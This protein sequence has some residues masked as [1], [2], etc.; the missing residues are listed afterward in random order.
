LC[1]GLPEA[2]TGLRQ[3]YVY[4]QCRSRS[5]PGCY[6]RALQALA[7]VFGALFTAAVC[8]TSGGAVLRNACEDRAV[9]LVTGAAVLSLFVFVLCAGGFAYPAV[10]A[11]IGGA[12]LA[13]GWREAHWSWPRRPKRVSGLLAIAFGVFSVLYLSNAMAPEISFD[14]SRYHLGLVA[15]YLREHGFHRITENMYASLSQGVEMLYLFA[16]AFG[17]HSAA[18]TL[19]F[20]FL[21]AL[22]WQVY[23]YA[24]DRGFTSVAGPA[25][26]LVFASP[27]A[28]VDGT[29]AYNDV[30]VAATAFTLFHLLQLW[31]SRRDR[32]LLIAAGLAAGFAFAAKY[33]AWVAVPYAVGF[34]AWKSRRWK[35]PAMVAICAALLIAPWM[36]KN[37][38]WVHNPVAPFYNHWFPN[39]YV[40]ES[41]ERE[42]RAHMRHYNLASDREIPMQVT[43][44]GSL[45]GLLGPVFLLAPIA[46]LA[47]RRREGGQLLL[48]AA[49]FGSTYFNNIGARFLLPVLP[50]A[51]LA[52]S[53]ALAQWPRAL[54]TTALV[55]AL[56]SW[57][58]ILKLY[59][60]E[61]SWHL[62]K[63]TYREALRIKPEEGFLE[64]NLPMYGAARMLDRLTPEGVTVFVFTPIPEAYT[65][66]NVLVAYQSAA[67]IRSRD[68]L[69]AAFDAPDPAR[70]AAVQSLKDRG[71]GCMLLFD[72]EIGA[73]RFRRDPAAWGIQEIGEYKGAR[74]YRFL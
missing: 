61:D 41:F 40:T 15:R 37:W 13:A 32:R 45:S 39:P 20:V 74:L 8:I 73:D 50:F 66:R 1:A 69:W 58:P 52:M 34:V 28:G 43:T 56:I 4:T 25:A 5:R 62:V 31:D 67:N 27:L 14:G 48:A 10:F 54:V 44:Y 24:R 46:L 60:H 2:H 49:V 3:T 59:A 29:S 6:N 19:H 30:A 68:L 65:S 12:I 7:I 26:L 23:R 22:T 70:R 51:A 47:L 33:T 72:G 21:L 63:V 38:L 9:R 57:P 16:F 55:H 64:S 71:V 35:E 18:S 42:Y 53:I 11:A 17:R 36:M